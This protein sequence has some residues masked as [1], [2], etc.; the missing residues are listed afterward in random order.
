M[1]IEERQ[2]YILKQ[3]NLYNKVHTAD[4]CTQLNVSLDTIR[5]DLA[6]LEK[7]GKLVKVHGGAISKSFHY[8]FQQPAVYAREKK[9]D[10]AK[11]ALELIEDGMIL[12]AGGGTV[13][14][15][16]ARMIPEN[17]KGTLFTVSPLV[18]LE[19]A[20][21]STVEVIL[22]GGQLSRNSYICTG[23]FVIRQL[24][25]IRVDLCFLGTNGIS[26]NEGVTDLDWEVVQV[27]KEMIKSAK[28]LAV[29]SIAEKLGSLQNLSVCSLNDVDYLIT[30][31]NPD[32]PKLSKYAKIFKVK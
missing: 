20:Q 26:L 11:K 3:I 31:L 14:L 7:S 27:K 13:M 25:E 1:L 17:L 12:L 22:I 8:P 29:L 30:E 16:L 15:E 28:K 23:S 21:R 19:V 24:S 10:I 4:L 5:R 9:K 32:D 18:A 2:N 6:E